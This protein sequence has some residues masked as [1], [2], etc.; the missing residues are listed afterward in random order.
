MLFAGSRRTG[1]AHERFRSA[2]H[3]FDVGVLVRCPE[4]SARPDAAADC[5]AEVA[6]LPAVAEATT[7][8]RLP[9]LLE[10][11]VGRSIQPNPDDPC[12]SDPGV[13]EAAYDASGRYGTTI[14]RSRFVAGRPANPNAADEVVLSQDTASRLG[15]HPGSEM[16]IR[17]FAG[18]RCDDAPEKWRAPQRV[19]VVGVQLSPA[20]IRPPSGTFLQTV[21][22]T[23][24]FVRR[25]GAVPDHL[26]DL[27]VRLRPDS[28]LGALRAQAKEAGHEI[29]VTLSQADT[30]SAVERAIRPNQVSLAI[31]AALTALAGAAVLGQILVRQTFA[32]STDDGLLA[33]L[34][35][36]APERVVLAAFRAGAVGLC[37]A[38]VA[39]LT[40]VV[41]SP[42]MPVGLAREVEPAPGFSVDGSTLAIGGL[43]TLAFVVAV[44]TATA[45]KLAMRRDRAVRAKRAAVAGLAARMGFSPAAV[46]GARLALERGAGTTAVPVASSFAGLAIAV[47]A[48]VG[49]LTFG[50]GLAHLQSTPRLIG[51]NWNV[52]MTYPQI[53]DPS[54]M[55]LADARA[56]AER[57][58]DTAGVVDVVKGTLWSPFPQGRDLQLGPEHVDVGG[59]MA[60]DGSARLGPSVI[61]GRKPSQSDEIMLGP[62]TISALGLHVGDEVDVI[63]QAGTSDSPG[64]ETST[65]MKIVGTGL[66]PMTESLG[67]G[68]VVTLEGL[69]RLSPGATE[70]AWFARLRPGVDRQ[71]A[72]DDYRRAFPRSMRASIETFGVERFELSALNLEQIESVPVLFAFIMGLMAVAVLAHVLA[73]TA[74]AR[75][76]DV[77][78][79]R[80]LGFSRGQTLRT[81]AW[82]ATIY[83]IGGLAIGVPVG[84]VLGRF[85]WR[86]YATHLGAV[87]EAVIPFGAC[88]AVAVTA[89]ALAGVLSILPALRLAR[90]RPGEALRAE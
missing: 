74:R 57:G 3:A 82:Q 81:V 37:A 16:R 41:C 76:R 65:R 83:A 47:A 11:I 6:G 1:N 60:F 20:E 21:R 45:A 38:A 44:T 4:A 18:A 77:A 31:L 26:D 42:F 46:S 84:V 34:G 61:T 27:V 13:V 17:L 56:R 28:S 39:I 5:R 49:A 63:G 68:A 51:W 9:A 53:E 64:E 2:Q 88:A 48:V 19:R 54:V 75:R 32:E 80:A 35:M 15:L 12:D 90:G 55:S 10:T 85:A 66:A 69:R 78:V 67:R 79:L 29:Q 8:T 70:Q 58:F 24:A 52:V 86:T 73:I 71:S 22:I 7:V 89:L 40:A 62:R 43:L 14:N 25:A 87:P 36:R 23:P 33:A 59:F 50:A 30:A 72:I